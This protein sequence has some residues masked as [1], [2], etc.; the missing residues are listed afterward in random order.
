MSPWKVLG[1]LLVALFA[2]LLVAVAYGLVLFYGWTLPSGKTLGVAAGGLAGLTLLVWLA[3]T[4]YR[5]SRSA[6]APLSVHLPVDRLP[7]WVLL[8]NNA[9]FPHLPE[10]FQHTG[11]PLLMDEPEETPDSVRLWSTKGAHWIAVSAATNARPERDSPASNTAKPAKPSSIWDKLLND[12]TVRRWLSP[13]AGIVLCLDMELLSA[14]D[15]KDAVAYLSQRVNALRVNALR[16]RLGNAPVY[17]LVTGLE[18]APGLLGL[19]QF[20]AAAPLLDTHSLH[21]PLGW[22]MLDR[23]PWTPVSRWALAGVR[24][25]MNLLLRSLD[26]LVRCS[27]AGTPAPGGSAFLFENALQPLTM[28]LAAL[29]TEIR[30]NGVFWEALPAVHPHPPAGGVGTPLF[31]RDLFL[32]TLPASCAQRSFP[33]VGRRRQIRT[34][35]RVAVTLLALAIA[36]ALYQGKEQ[37]AA[38]LPRIHQLEHFQREKALD[39]SLAQATS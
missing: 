27:D 9:L 16:G 36:L 6:P 26:A 3:L 32:E 2:L 30:F 31:V 29:A 23:K 25:G 1:W 17:L 12:K 15:G 5:R 39:E 4:L 13:P 34:A 28:P 33:L 19:V 38:L 21:A 18:R 8:D 22:I 11:S 14:S 35:R 20:L 7:R 10:L 24:E 37:G